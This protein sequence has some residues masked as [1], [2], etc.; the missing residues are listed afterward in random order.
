MC[1]LK[2]KRQFFSFSKTKKR[3]LTASN[4][5]VFIIDKSLSLSIDTNNLISQ[6]GFEGLWYGC[7][8]HDRTSY[9]YTLVRRAS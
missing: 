4:K 3:S 2:K 8:V 1:Y 6:Y 5:N 9:L 7:R